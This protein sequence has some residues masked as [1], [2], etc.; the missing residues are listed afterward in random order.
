MVI[1]RP[2]I[3]PGVLQFCC[4]G[5]D[6]RAAIGFDDSYTAVTW[7]AHALLSVVLPAAYSTPAASADPGS[8]EYGRNNTSPAY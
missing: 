5:S 1:S 3:Q 2:S 7:T 6:F 8:F 4:Y